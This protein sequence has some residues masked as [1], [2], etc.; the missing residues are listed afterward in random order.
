MKCEYSMLLHFYK[1]NLEL[2]TLFHEIHFFKFT[3]AVF[4]NLYQQTVF[5]VS[6]TIKS[7]LVTNL[8]F[9]S[10][11]FFSATYLEQFL[12]KCIISFSSILVTFKFYFFGHQMFFS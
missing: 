8:S 3:L 10:F 1:K 9:Q 7:I 2:P 11:I 12:A 5:G 6:L 4:M